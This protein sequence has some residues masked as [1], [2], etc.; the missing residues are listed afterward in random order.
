MI[1]V[2]FFL[3]KIGYNANIEFE[4]SFKLANKIMEDNE[5]FTNLYR[6]KI[7]PNK[8][9]EIKFFIYKALNLEK[10][11]VKM[12]RAF[13]EYVCYEAYQKFRTLE[14]QIYPDPLIDQLSKIFL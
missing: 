13:R 1:N 7:Q 6:K 5:N 9:Y 8:S 2:S 3:L 11:D 4:S 10:H 12:R 14:V